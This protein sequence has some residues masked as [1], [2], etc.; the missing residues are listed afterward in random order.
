MRVF[1]LLLVGAT[2]ACAKPSGPVLEGDRWEA[3]G[4]V[5]E[6]RGD[7][8]L[9]L[10]MDDGSTVQ[11]EVPQ[12]A[13]VRIEA[14]EVPSIRALFEGDRVR[15]TW[16]GEATEGDAK[17]VVVTRPTIIWQN[18]EAA[19]EAITEPTAPEWADTTDSPGGTMEA[20]W[21]VGT[22]G[23]HQPIR[24]LGPK[25]VNAVTGE[26]VPSDERPSF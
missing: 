23:Y 22:W 19:E 24:E 14:R 8:L 2:F 1:V 4:V 12:Q 9:L 17:E 6:R 11:L 18:V 10:R 15:S 16:T 20:P 3:E 13:E 21:Y 26:L 5:I 7:D 25:H